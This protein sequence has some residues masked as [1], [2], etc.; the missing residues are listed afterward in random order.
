MTTS[1][2]DRPQSQP[3]GAAQPVDP[4]KLAEKVYQL[5]L[6]DL[7]IARARGARPARPRRKP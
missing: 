4:K 6:A 2:S 1:Q 7:R 5:M 3:G